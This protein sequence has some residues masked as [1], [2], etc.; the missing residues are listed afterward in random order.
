MTGS[1]P[2]TGRAPHVPVLLRPLL[3]AVAPVQGV[4]LDGTFGAGGYARGLLAAGA[5]RAQAAGAVAQLGNLGTT[6]GT[7]LLSA[8]ILGFGSTGRQSMG[9]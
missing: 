3:A 5:D 8:L 6:T 7:P 1:D 4:W 2:E 9:A